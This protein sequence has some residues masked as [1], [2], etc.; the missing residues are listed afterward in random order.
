[1]K[2]TKLI[3]LLGIFS[4]LT[5]CKTKNSEKR[6]SVT[7]EKNKSDLLIPNNDLDQKI[8][9]LEIEL[10]HTPI[11]ELDSIKQVCTKIFNLDKYNETAIY[12]LVESYRYPFEDPI[13][14][15]FE[16][17]KNFNS[18]TKNNYKDS[19]NLFFKKLRENDKSNPK[20]L[21][22]EA[23]YKFGRILSYDSIKIKPL[24]KALALDKN[25]IEANLLLGETFYHIFNNE[26]KKNS[27]NP[28]LKNLATKSFNYLQLVF[29]L[30]NSSKSLLR[31]TLIQLANYL[32]YSEK[33]I[34]YKKY[35]GN[36]T[37][38]FPLK[39]FGSFP[40]NWNRNYQINVIN[41]I[42][43]SQFV[44]KWYSNH[45]KAMEEPILFDNSS[46]TNSFRFTWLRT[47]HNPIIVRL[48]NKNGQIF[49][50]WKVC[51]GAGG[52]EPGKVIINVQKE[53]PLEK[54]TEFQ[55][56]ISSINFW[57]T[58][59][60]LDEFPGHD[61]SQ[62][63][64]EGVTEKQYHV[65]DR[66]TPRGTAYAKCCDFLLNLTDLKIKAKEKY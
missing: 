48:D 44:N 34:Y 7:E 10:R 8:K 2:S 59:T 42:E 58:P 18:L 45:L 32:N 6:L 54:W 51:D 49:L 9:L 20:P 3:F 16:K 64:L 62:W 66:W 27:N 1:M 30:E 11:S 53:L 31:Y 46:I 24:E 38:F 15:T 56:I 33:L 65:V 28:K 5:F 35:Q 13:I 17:N 4:I 23:K 47:F 22:L 43:I 41:E 29:N 37:L 25:N 40:I 63:I 21:I 60:I 19:L 26:Y 12:Y 57:D 36:S 39:T 52:Y 14:N 50:T 55:K 61:G